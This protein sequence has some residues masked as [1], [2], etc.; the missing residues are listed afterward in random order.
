MIL[1]FLLCLQQMRVQWNKHHFSESF[2]VSNGVLQGS[3]L[4]PVL[5]AMVVGRIVQ[6]RCWL[7]LEVV[8]CWCFLLC[9]R[10]RSIGTLCVSSA[11]HVIHL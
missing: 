9:G 1:R 7:S 3:V 11:A 8:V 10:H 4:S 6:L 2:T 5:F